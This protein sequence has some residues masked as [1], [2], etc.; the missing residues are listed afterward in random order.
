[1]GNTS[2]SEGTSSEGTFSSSTIITTSDTSLLFEPQLEHISPLI[3]G[4]CKKREKN[5]ESDYHCKKLRQVLYCVVQNKMR[6]GEIQNRGTTIHN[7]CS[8][9]LMSD[10]TG[11]WSSDYHVKHILGEAKY[12]SGRVASEMDQIYKKMQNFKVEKVES[13]EKFVI[14]VNVR[15]V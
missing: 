13:P 10:N 6:E 12:S 14:E 2:S 9:P 5:G 15:K 1:M 11:K 8:D 7:F 3:D 4:L